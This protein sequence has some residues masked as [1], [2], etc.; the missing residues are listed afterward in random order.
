VN[1]VITAPETPGHGLKVKPEIMKDFAV[2]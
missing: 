2:Q 1:G